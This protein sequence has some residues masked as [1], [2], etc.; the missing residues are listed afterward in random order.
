MFVSA[1]QRLLAVL[2]EYDRLLDAEKFVSQK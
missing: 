2:T 1:S